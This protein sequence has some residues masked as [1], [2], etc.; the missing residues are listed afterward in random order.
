[1]VIS[2]R[3][4]RV[5]LGVLLALSAANVATA[6][7]TRTVEAAQLAALLQDTIASAN[8]HRTSANV[9]V[10]EYFDYNCPVCRA[11][12]PDL[13]KLVTADPR[14]QL[15][16]KDWTIFGDGS[17]YAAYAAFAAAREGKYQAAHDA[18]IGSTQDLDTRSDVRAVLKGAGL[19][20]AKI[21]SDV[22]S[23]E[24]EYAARLARVRGEAEMLGLHGTP[25]LIVGN[26][27]VVS[28]KTDYVRLQRLVAA[29]RAHP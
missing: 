6:Q 8:S 15:V 7:G 1:M 17:V 13:R 26:Q 29:A 4:Y 5:L 19:D 16:R 9:T 14:I 12:D 24:K 20:T 11:L 23:H 25:G 21:D 28:G 18:L 27:L 3:V 22:A 10:V 2:T